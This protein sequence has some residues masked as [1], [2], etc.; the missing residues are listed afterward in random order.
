MLLFSGERGDQK[1]LSLVNNYYICVHLYIIK[2]KQLKPNRVWTSRAE[3]PW[4]W[5]WSELNRLTLYIVRRWCNALS[6]AISQYYT[7]FVSPYTCILM[8]KGCHRN[9][10]HFCRTLTRYSTLHIHVCDTYEAQSAVRLS[11][12]WFYWHINLAWSARWLGFMS[13]YIGFTF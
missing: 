10:P 3:M 4:F 6:Y 11:Q 8:L 13:T 9:T 5:T 2:N 12:S 1:D 7:Q